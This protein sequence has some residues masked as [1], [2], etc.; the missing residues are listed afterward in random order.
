MPLYLCSSPKNLIAEER[1]PAIAKELTHIHCDVTGAPSSF[2]HIF[3]VNQDDEGDGS[4]NLFGSI[5]GGR[6]DDQ[7]TEIT[8]RMSAAVARL[9]DLDPASVSM[10]TVDVPAKWA[11]EGGDIMP[12]PGEEAAWFAAHAAKAAAS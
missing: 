4:V 8:S 12:E 5:R 7:K 11:M 1:K 9:A 10:G 6:S 3:F 2:V